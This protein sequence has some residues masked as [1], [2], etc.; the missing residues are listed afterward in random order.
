M[1]LGRSVAPCYTCGP[2]EQIGRK[3]DDE[4][5]ERTNFIMDQT[6]TTTNTVVHYYISCILC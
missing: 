4:A 5:Y 3:S 6:L 2:E 1:G